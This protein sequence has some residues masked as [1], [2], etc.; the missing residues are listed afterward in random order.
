MAQLAFN[1][2]LPSYEYVPDGEPHVWGD[3]VYVYGSHDRF[4]GYAFCMNDYVGWSA[5]LDDLGNWRC[6]G[7]IYPR[8]QDPNGS[9]GVVRH[10]MAAPDCCQGP[11]GRYYLYYF[12]GDHYIKAAVCDEP[13]GRYQYYGAVH[14]A[15][16]TNL[17]DRD[18]P[19]MFDPGMLVDDDGRIYLYVGFGLTSNPLLLDG[20]K[21]TPH[22]AMVFE[23]EP[24]MLTVKPAY[25]EI[26]YIGI[27]GIKEGKGTEYEGHEFLEASSMRK[28][29][30]RYYFIYSSYVG[31]ELCWAVSDS[32][33]GGFRY[34]GVLVSNG[35]IGL[36]GRSIKDALNYTGN[37]HGSLVK[38]GEKYYIFYHRHTNGKCYSRQACAEEIRFENGRFLQAEITSCGLNG[39]PLPGEGTYEARIAC[40]LRSRKGTKFYIAFR[41]ISG[42]HPYFTQTGEDREDNP[43]QYITNIR[44]GAMAGFKYFDCDGTD[45]I[46]V[47]GKGSARGEMVVTTKIGGEPVTRIP[48]TPSRN[49]ADY[50]APLIAP[51]LG[52]T[53]LYF[54]FEGKGKFDFHAFTLR[55]T[56]REQPE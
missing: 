41:G 12:L 25:E 48:I 4:N 17:G 47:N 40:N 26:H 45:R 27:R 37:N 14:Y 11:D 13:A 56:Q 8:S 10:G 21:P 33:V 22:G 43:D 50:D 54:T 32:P 36:G 38:I 29:D 9:L 51:L 5:P 3:R 53:A 20:E 44:D 52:V 15:D 34:G 31:H 46:S 35:D 30:G 39:G 18:E 42:P 55:K 16:G 1:P 6:E 28:Y 2:Y 49:A 23:L 24:D 7:V 19:K